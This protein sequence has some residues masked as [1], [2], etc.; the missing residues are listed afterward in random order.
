MY[1][2]MCSALPVIREMQ[3]KTW[4]YLAPTG[5]AKSLNYMVL[6]RMEWNRYSSENINLYQSLETNWQYSTK[7][8]V[9]ILQYSDSQPWVILSFWK[10]SGGILVFTTVGVSLSHLPST[11]PSDQV[12][13]CILKGRKLT[14][15]SFRHSSNS[16]WR[17]SPPCK[18]NGTTWWV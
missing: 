6:V 3:T 4:Y 9:C 16:G 1:K 17:G 12:T 8:K 10:I 2:K 15:A 18:W 11:G 7:L 14:P 5:L 13:G